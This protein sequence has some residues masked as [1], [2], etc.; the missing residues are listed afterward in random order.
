M[1]LLPVLPA[2]S[3]ERSSRRKRWSYRYQES[4]AVAV[5]SWRRSKPSLPEPAGASNCSLP[6]ESG[7][8]DARTPDASRP[9]GVSEPREA[10]GVRPII[11]AF[12]PARDSPRFLVPMHAKKRKG[13]FHEPERRTPVRQGVLRPPNR[14]CAEREFGAPSVRLRTDTTGVFPSGPGTCHSVMIF[15]PSMVFTGYQVSSFNR[16]TK[17]NDCAVP[18]LIRLPDG[19]R[20]SWSDC[21]AS[22][23]CFSSGAYFSR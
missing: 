1:S 4:P 5:R 20:D 10:S 9:P 11:G 19:T 18:R 2:K 6:W 8:E 15:S 22:N 3:F 12:R 14:H 7:A 21:M 13:A 16:R 17:I 23:C